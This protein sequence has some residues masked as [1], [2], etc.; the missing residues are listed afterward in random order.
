MASLPSLQP[1]KQSFV[2]LIGSN[3]RRNCYSDIQRAVNC[4]V[5]VHFIKRHAYS[6]HNTIKG[7][8][9][10]R[11]GGERTENAKYSSGMG[12]AQRARVKEAAPAVVFDIGR[13][14]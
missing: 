7:M 5:A 4:E 2:Q 3:H 11:G 9:D 1:L 13:E 8:L 6:L 12:T 10:R 14:R